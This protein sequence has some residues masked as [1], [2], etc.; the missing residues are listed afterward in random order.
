M[1]DGLDFKEA[2]ATLVFGS[3]DKIYVETITTVPKNAELL[4]SYGPLYWLNLLEQTSLLPGG[5]G[6]RWDIKGEEEQDLA[7]ESSVT[8]RQRDT[9][10]SGSNSP[11]HASHYTLQA[12]AYCS[13][14]CYD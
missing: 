10:S 13:T 14:G 5:S 8:V 1:N 3:D 4:L 11:L 9:E 12:I 6:G 2:N 7:V